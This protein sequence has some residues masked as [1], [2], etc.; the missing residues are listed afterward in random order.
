VPPR[1][2]PR[3]D[4]VLCDCALVC[5]FLV[6]LQNATGSLLAAALA[7]G[8]NAHVGAFKDNTAALVSG[9]SWDD[10]T[11]A[12]NL[13]CGSAG[14]NIWSSDQPNGDVSPTNNTLYGAVC[15]NCGGGG[16]G[17]LSDLGPT[18][19]EARICEVE[20]QCAA[21]HTCYTAAQVCMGVC[22]FPQ[23]SSGSLGERLQTV[24]KVAL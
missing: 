4:G 23:A 13:N 15:P 17:E 24:L 20:W 18:S 1:R 21:G 6:A 10:G 22:L 7:Y 8:I 11:P 5:V 19:T 2:M 9:W 3:I 16:M 12:T 14:C